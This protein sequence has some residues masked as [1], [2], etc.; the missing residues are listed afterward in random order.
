MALYGQVIRRPVGFSLV[1]LFLLQRLFPALSQ[2]WGQEVVAAYFVVTPVGERLGEEVGG[3][4]VHCRFLYNSPMFHLTPHPRFPWYPMSSNPK[5][6][7]DCV[8]GHGLILT[9]I[10]LVRHLGSN[11]LNSVIPNFYGLSCSTMYQIYLSIFFP[12]F[13]IF[14]F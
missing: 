13:F 6:L 14:V 2:R 8:I 4:S 7:R 9:S 3:S 11:F 10:P 1:P 12:L 5:N